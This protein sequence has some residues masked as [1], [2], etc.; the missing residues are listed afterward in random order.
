MCCVLCGIMW[1]FYVYNF[2]GF[3]GFS[4]PLA[5][6]PLDVHKTSQVVHGLGPRLNQVGQSEERDP[7]STGFDEESDTS[8]AMAA[9]LA[10]LA[11][12]QEWIA[13]FKKNLLWGI[14]F[15]TEIR[16]M[17]KGSLL[18]SIETEVVTPYLL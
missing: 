5:Q 8:M 16:Q 2:E 10:E 13:A 17:E 4:D 15:P 18:F 7:P 3:A 1:L 6:V 9:V 14:G 12:Q 11:T